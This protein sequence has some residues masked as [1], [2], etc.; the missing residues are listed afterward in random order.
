MY[1]LVY[2]R[3]AVRSLRKIPS[4]I[5]KRIC[6]KLERLANNPYIKNNNVKS[7][8]GSNANYRLRIGDWRALYILD[9][10]E[11]Q[12]IIVDINVRGEVYNP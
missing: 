11:K 8:K 10:Q 3:E 4:N 1:K 6:M 9:D 2:S 7:F 12:I 5:A